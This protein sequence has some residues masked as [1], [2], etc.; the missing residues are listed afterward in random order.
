[1]NPAVIIARLNFA[2]A[3]SAANTSRCVPVDDGSSS[4]GERY[5]SI[6]AFFLLPKRLEARRSCGENDGRMEETA[7]TGG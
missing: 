1:M 3:A 4:L 6:I 2:A 7:M 5:D